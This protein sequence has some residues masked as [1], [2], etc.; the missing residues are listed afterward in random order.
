MASSNARLTDEERPWQGI[1]PWLLKRGYM[2]RARYRSGWKPSG[3]PQD[4]AENL[5]GL[6][7]P[8]IMDAIRTSDGKAVMLKKVAKSQHPLEAEISQFLSSPPLSEDPHNHSVPIHDILQIPDNE[9]TILL[10]MPLL[11]PFNDPELQTIGEAFDFVHQLFEGL[12]FLHDQHV[13][14]RDIKGVDIMLDLSSMFPETRHP[15]APPPKHGNCGGSAKSFS[16]TEQPSKY[17]YSGFGHARKYNLDDGPPAEMPYVGD[18]KS[19]PEFQGSGAK[20]PSNPFPTDVYYVGKLI[21]EYL[22]Q[23]YYGVE[24]LEPLVADMIQADPQSRPTIDEVIARFAE[25]QRAQP[26]ILFR[27]R[28]VGKQDTI[29]TRINLEMGHLKR[30]VNYSVRGLPAIPDYTRRS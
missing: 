27:I 16:R 14:H 24:S 5:L 9:D 13:A 28:L 11:R 30:Q 26:S 29:L 15:K 19:V 1:Q 12:K 20:E 22:S 21:K 10:V 18:D 2:L 6:P 25:I 4:D 8:G 17:Y 3:V 7:Y 23:K